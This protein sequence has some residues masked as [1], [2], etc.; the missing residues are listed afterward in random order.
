MRPHGTQQQLEQ[1]RRRAIAMLRSGK[2][3]RFVAQKLKAS[4]SSVIRW[5]QMHRRKG[6]AGL[7][8]S[9]WG[10]PSHLSERQKENTLQLLA[11]GA[12]A[13]GHTT[14][15]W[16]LKRISQLIE[17]HHG[18]RYSQVGVWKLLRTGFRW[19]SQKP[20]RR[21]TQRN[22]KA[23]AFWKRC[24]WPRIKKS[25]KTPGLLGVSR[26]KRLPAHSQRS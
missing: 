24:T 9:R 2:P 18:V 19:S 4:L 8:S 20:E 5:R 3:Y 16:T 22:D 12:L 26:R 21:A 25:S 6:R 11:R 14:E 17:K 23:I 15:L 1:R 10:R 7:R 13:A